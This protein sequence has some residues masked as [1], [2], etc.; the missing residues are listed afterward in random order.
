MKNSLIF[1]Y[2]SSDRF[3]PLYPG[4]QHLATRCHRFF[5][6]LQEK[7]EP[8]SKTDGNMGHWQ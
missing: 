3:S 2:N 8:L 4:P 1:V 7:I 6:E 5:Q